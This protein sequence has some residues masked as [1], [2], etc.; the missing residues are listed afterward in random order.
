MMLKLHNVRKKKREPPNVTKECDVG[1]V[2]CED[3]IVKCEEKKKRN[4]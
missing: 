4:H 1:T 2:Q 3:R